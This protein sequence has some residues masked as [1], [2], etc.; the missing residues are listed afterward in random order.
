MYLNNYY[1]LTSTS[2]IDIKLRKEYYHFT[3]CEFFTLA[4][5]VGFSL[6]LVE[7]YLLNSPE[8]S[9]VF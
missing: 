9:S 3:S 6:F 1:Q 5:S 8:L 7:K 4:M 2:F